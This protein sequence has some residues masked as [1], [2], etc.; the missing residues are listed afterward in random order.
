MFRTVP[1]ILAT[2][3]LVVLQALGSISASAQDAAALLQ[4]AWK[5]WK[6][7]DVL[8]AEKMAQK[9]PTTSDT[10]AL[11]F[12]CAFVKGEYEAALLH[13]AKIDASHAKRK[14]LNEAVVQAYLHL[15]RPKEAL[16]FA[17]ER[18]MG[19]AMLTSLEMRA[20]HPFQSQLKRVAVVPFA[21]HNLTPYFPAFDAELEGEKIKVHVDTGGNFLVMGQERAQKMGI[22]LKDVGEGFH[23]ATRVKLQA[24]VAKKFVLGDAV[25]ENVPVTVMPTLKGPQDFVIFGT[26]ILEPFLA[27]LDYPKSRLILSPRKDKD[28]AKKHLEMLPEKRVEVL[29]Y[30][31]GDHYMFARGGFGK[32]RDLNF[33]IDSGLLLLAPVKGKPR[34][35]C[36]LATPQ[37]YKEWGVD[38]A[39]AEKKTFESSLPITLGPLEQKDQFFAT[40]GQT[41]WNFFGGV[42][43]DGLLSHAFLYKYT[44]TIDFERRRYVFGE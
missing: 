18:K 20:Q 40:A 4:D 8:E 39:L 1:S 22:A 36:F 7:G 34:Q 35:A 25:F 21:K 23:A 31:W 24:G 30:L 15:G 16:D 37:L 33:F 5:S 26:N 42:R 11:L 41:A 17:R 13:H 32:R 43:I 14:E 38:A 9:S 44:W 12:L 27:T 19:E 29:F 28:L 10:H 3:L 6:N 2:C